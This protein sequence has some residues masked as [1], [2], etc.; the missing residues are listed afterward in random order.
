MENCLY[1]YSATQMSVVG[2]SQA[3]FKVQA[4]IESV[5]ES[6]ELRVRVGP[7]ICMYV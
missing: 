5:C 2:E 1:A 4:D 7:I 3:I 6:G